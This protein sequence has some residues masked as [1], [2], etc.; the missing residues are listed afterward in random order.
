MVQHVFETPPRLSVPS[1]K[2]ATAY[3]D[4]NAFGRT[5]SSASPDLYLMGLIYPSRAEMFTEVELD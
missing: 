4:L 3:E 5:L 1:T 2:T